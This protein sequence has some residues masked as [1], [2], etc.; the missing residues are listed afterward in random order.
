MITQAQAAAEL[1][2]RRRARQD[3]L[4][5][6][7]YT[8]PKWDS[9]SHHRTICDALQ[10]VL[11][12]KCKRMM[13]FA[14]PRHTKTELASKRFPA[15]YLGK[16]PD[17]QIICAQHTDQLAKDTGADV[18]DIIADERYKILF[19]GT[20]LNPD[21]KAAG[22]WRT[23]E[24][25]IY[26]STGVGGAI[27]GRGADLAVID[28]PIKGR[29]D[30]ESPR[31]RELAW[32]WFM[33]DLVNR[34]QPDGA[35]V[36]MMTRWHEDDLAARALKIDDWEVIELKAIANEG[37]EYEEALWPEW[38]PL[39]EL[40][41]KK[42]AF[43]KGGRIR[44]WESQYQQNP[45]PEQGTFIK[46]DW[47]KERWTNEVLLEH[48]NKYCFTDFATVEDTEDTNPD[49]TSHGIFGIGEQKRP[50]RRDWWSKQA[51][52]NEWV[53]ALFALHKKHGFL[54]WFAEK[55]AIFNTILPVV[56]TR[57]KESGQHFRVEGMSAAGSKRVKALAFQAMAQ[58]GDFVFGTDEIDELIIDQCVNFPAAA[59]DDDFDVCGMVCR[60]IEQQ[61]EA[62]IEEEVDEAK[63]DRYKAYG[64]SETNDGEWIAG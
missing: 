16:K 17:R 20:Q 30:A 47:F 23:T 15:Y 19:P 44:E 38:W 31:M 11:D 29:N 6:A 27:P 25:G 35:I 51:S 57:M 24:G 58:A 8:H 61:H 42:A 12:G 46:R 43:V 64:E 9:G 39:P 36:F 1:L 5:F 32:R 45:K 37:T 48:Q 62:F 54:V 14:P 2:L 34:L 53:D 56:R 40:K 41:K 59:H 63:E 7:A 28:D 50:H 60:A 55:G 13:L 33:G 52:S 3:L 18:R 10:R 22:R 4:D 26:I 21:A 49:Y